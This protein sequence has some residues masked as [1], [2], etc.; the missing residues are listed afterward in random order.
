VLRVLDD[1]ARSLAIP[2]P[3][4]NLAGTRKG[5][6]V[7]LTLTP[8]RLARDEIDAKLAACGSVVLEHTSA[9]C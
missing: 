6:A 7:P 4:A 2:P 8:E 3:C 5:S 1:D 9:A